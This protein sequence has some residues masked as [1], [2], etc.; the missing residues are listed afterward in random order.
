AGQLAR[1][2]N[3]RL[4]QALEPLLLGQPGQLQL[5][6]GRAIDGLLVGV[7]VQVAGLAGGRQHLLTAIAELVEGGVERGDAGLGLSGGC[8][9]LYLLDLGISCLQLSKKSASVQAKCRSVRLLCLQ[10]SRK[11]ASTGRLRRSFTGLLL[12]S[13]E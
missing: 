13:E 1:D 6:L 12:R 9:E 10:L 7:E 4:D 2:I 5:K 8:H 11:T 3:L